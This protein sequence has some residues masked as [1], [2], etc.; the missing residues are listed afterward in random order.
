MSAVTV[1]IILQLL[2]I[3]TTLVALRSPLAREE[4]PLLRHLFDR[5]GV[6]PTLVVLKLAYI[7]ALLLLGASVDQ[8]LLWLLS[9]LYVWAIWGNLKIIR[10]VRRQH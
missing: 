9:G 3:V 10:Q 1:L 7:V 2:D 5:L 6:A 8:R 4:N